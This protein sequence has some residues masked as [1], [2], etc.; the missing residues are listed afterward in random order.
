MVSDVVLGSSLRAQLFA[1]TRTTRSI[2]TTQLR[3][4]TGLKVN[5]AL[6][7][8]Q[9]FFASAALKSRASDLQRLL[10]NIGQNIQVIKAADNG[11]AALGTLVEQAEAVAQQ[12]LDILPTLQSEAKAAGEKNLAEIDDLTSLSGVA[13]GDRLRFTF[14]APDE[15]NINPPAS[16]VSISTNMSGAELVLAIN[17]LNNALTEETIEASLNDNGELEIKT[18]NGDIMMIEFVSGAVGTGTQASN[19]AIANALGFGQ[20]TEFSNDLLHQN[21][22]GFV[23]YPGSSLESFEF[24]DFTTG[25]TA[26]RSS[27]LNNL[28]TSTGLNPFFNF[29]SPADQYQIGV[30]G[31][32][33]QSITVDATTT[34]QGF[35]DAI[36]TDISLSDF[37]E[38]G[39]NE[40]TGQ[41]T[42]SPISN[43]Q[44]I[45]IGAASPDIM[46][47]FLGF[48]VRAPV[49]FGPIF[50]PD[51]TSIR[52]PSATEEL[53]DLE[54]EFDNIREQ[55]DTLIRNGDAG[56]RGTNLLNGDRLETFFNEL[57][58]SSLITYGIE[59][60]SD[61]LGLGDA[62]F[63]SAASIEDTLTDVREALITVRNFGSALANDLNI[64]Q[65]RETALQQI[66]N[67]LDEGSDELTVAD[68]NEEGAKM[69]SLQVTQQMSVT[70]LALAS[71][72]QQA[73]LR[74]F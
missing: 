44:S 63:V 13:N 48:D 8:P 5:S 43:V 73:I 47:A 50:T 66:I 55:I 56:Y 32:T 23:V 7:N 39:F 2:D 52:L 57:R 35:I 64:I 15:E 45:E 74:L 59:L 34:V 33:L 1:L 69:L 19:L 41:I 58:S 40:E 11:V 67:T 6:D 24:T 26:R 71:Q 17:D 49:A 18:V 60:S 10:D 20:Q 68:Q 65:A 9:N 36:N 61:G 62:N 27:V 38:A 22:V 42:I 29:A 3:L 72:A 70:A 12:A 46:I 54:N 21:S 25:E 31:G 28:R 30:N 53:A 14:R 4:A 51:V 16:T 37:I